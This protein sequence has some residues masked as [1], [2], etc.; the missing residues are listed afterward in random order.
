MKVNHKY[1]ITQPEEYFLDQHGQ[2]DSFPEIM[3]FVKVL[4]TSIKSPSGNTVLVECLNTGEEYPFPIE[5]NY[6]VEEIL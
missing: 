6:L 2:E 1:K 4:D 5:Y 3:R